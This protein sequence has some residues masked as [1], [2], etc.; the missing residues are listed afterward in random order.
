M[1]KTYKGIDLLDAII[2]GEV[3]IK[4]KVDVLDKNGELFMSNY[5]I[6]DLCITSIT[7]YD[8]KLTEKQDIDIQSIEEYK[9]EYTRD[10]SMIDMETYINNVILPA[11]KQLDRKIREER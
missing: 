7:K 5:S 4:D 8:F 2:K 9:S 3:R 10:L 1:S 11:I 6:E